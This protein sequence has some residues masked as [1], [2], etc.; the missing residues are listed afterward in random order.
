MAVQPHFALDSNLVIS[1]HP[2]TDIAFDTT[3]QIIF[4]VLPPSIGKSFLI[5]LIFMC[6]CL[7]ASFMEFLNHIRFDIRLMRKPGWKDPAKCISR[8]AYFYCRFGGMACLLLVVL[9]LSLK[10][11]DCVAMP[12]AFAIGNLLLYFAVTLIFVQRTMALYSWKRFVVVPLTILYTVAI[13]TATICF[14]FYGSGFRIPGTRF[15]AYDT[16][17]GNVRT[18]VLAI[19][20]KVMSMILDLTLLLL[21]LHRLLDGGL[22]ALRL[23]RP[24]ALH[25]GLADQAL[26][27]FLIRQGFHFY[28]LQVFTDVFYM[29]TYFT[30]KNASYQ[31]LG[32]TLVFTVP[33]IAAASAFRNMGKKASQVTSKNAN[34]VNEIMNSDNTPSG[35]NSGARGRSITRNSAAPQQQ[36]LAAAVQ[37]MGTT[38]MFVPAEVTRPEK[39]TRISWGARGHAFNHSRHDPADF[40]NGVIITVGTVSHTEDV[41]A[42]ASSGA[43]SPR[44]SS[45]N[46]DP[47]LH[48]M[49]RQWPPK[50][51]SECSQ[52]TETQFEPVPVLGRMSAPLQRAGTSGSN[53]SW[54]PRTPEMP[55]PEPLLSPRDFARPATA[56]EN[57]N[58][59]VPV[60]R[61]FAD[62]Q[63]TH[64]KVV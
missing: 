35:E 40:E 30:F 48:E 21:T 22:P 20:F 18:L 54:F 50:L 3:P 43:N 4:N 17:R 49:Q 24:Q 33:P 61:A 58:R 15:C 46:P 34:R 23:K 63:D 12:W 29:S 41:D 14:P 38:H 19:L 6:F 62:D 42:R 47:E 36:Q 55:Y 16:K 56:P 31:S 45:D 2:H 57:S 26:S 52:T 53:S 7:G 25:P 39:T 5:L 10:L 13:C 37:L 28:L 9:F 44:Y 27:G 64:S 11:D 1:P 60:P 8:L 51:T 32:T 59:R